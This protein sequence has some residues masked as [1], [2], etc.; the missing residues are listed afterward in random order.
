MVRQPLSVSIG[1]GFLLCLGKWDGGWGFSVMFQ[2]I[3]FLFCVIVLLG[4]SCMQF[5]IVFF[6]DAS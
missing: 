5:A 1:I 4:E 2:F 3:C 6:I